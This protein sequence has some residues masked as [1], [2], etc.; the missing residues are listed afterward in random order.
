MEEEGRVMDEVTRQADGSGKIGQRYHATD[1]AEETRNGGDQEPEKKRRLLETLR[2]DFPSLNH[3]PD[4]YILQQS[5]SGLTKAHAKMEGRSGRGGRLS[6]E[7]RMARNF[8]DS[9]GRKIQLAAGEDDRISTI[10]EGRFLPGLLCTIGETFRA[11]KGILPERGHDPVAHYDARGLGLGYLVSAKAWAAVHDPGCTDICLGMFTHAA[12]SAGSSEAATKFKC[13]DLDEFKQTLSHA[14]AVQQL[15]NPWNYSI[16]AIHLYLENI[17][18]GYRYFSNQKDHVKGLMTFVDQTLLA[19]AT[20]WQKKL[21]LPCLNAAEL[22]QSL[23]LYVAGRGSE[24]RTQYS[25]S[26]RRSVSPLSREKTKRWEKLS[27]SAIC[28]R[29]NAGICPSKDDSCRIRGFNLRHRCSYPLKNGKLCEE[30]HP[31]KDH[32]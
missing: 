18:W 7:T 8:K 30:R 6:L 22:K 32:K 15:V 20:N 27:E 5:A 1:G 19:N 11:A 31:E 21:G 24:N 29:Y 9:N 25:S 17:K 16:T 10:H 23:D 2:R 13:E 28:G 26:R 12:G 14:R 3:W 4:S